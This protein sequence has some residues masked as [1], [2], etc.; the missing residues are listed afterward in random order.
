MVEFMILK[1]FN[2]KIHPPKTPKI[3]D[4]LWHPP[5]IAWI[6]CNLDREVTDSSGIASNGGV[7]ETIKLAF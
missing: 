4:I 1:N 5:I 3:K 6:K 2:V 7:L